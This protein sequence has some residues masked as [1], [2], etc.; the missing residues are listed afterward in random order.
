MERIYCFYFISNRVEERVEY[1]IGWSVRPLNAL[2]QT[3][4]KNWFQNRVWL[5][6]DLNPGPLTYDTHPPSSKRRLLYRANSHSIVLKWKFVNSVVLSAHSLL[7]CMWY[8]AS[9]ERR[10]EE[11]REYSCGEKVSYSRGN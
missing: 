8:P 4:M 1:R 2:A 7:H 3:A 5:E 9:E 11:R 6:Q 10:G